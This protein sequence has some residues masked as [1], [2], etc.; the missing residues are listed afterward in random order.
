VEFFRMNLLAMGMYAPLLRSILRCSPF[1]FAELRSP[2]CGFFLLRRVFTFYIIRLEV[3]I[4]IYVFFMSRTF[5]FMSRTF[6]FM[7]RTFQG[8]YLLLI[9]L[10]K[11]LVYVL[12]CISKICI[13]QQVLS[14]NN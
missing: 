13:R 5:P 11:N 7:S 4:F 14:L 9:G 3:I 10:T 8:L 2:S 12:Y 6:S 1:F